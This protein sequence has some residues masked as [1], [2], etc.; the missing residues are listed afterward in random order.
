MSE[1]FVKIAQ[2]Q[3]QGMI[4]LRVDLADDAACGAVQTAL[5]LDVPAPHCVTMDAERGLVWMSKDEL[6]ILCPME[7]VG[8]LL[9]D[10]KAALA[11][12][13]HL[14]A[15]AS[16]ARAVFD[17]KGKM[18]RDVLAK[19]T[20]AD[21]HPDVFPMG[22]VRRTRLGQVAAAVWLPGK[23]AARVVCFRSVEAYMQL[24]NTAAQNGAQVM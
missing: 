12:V 21:M 6:L 19:L 3:N 1:T 5:G 7:G 20:P 4:T 8:A 22:Q 11:N 15:D 14:L 9:S 24:L 17:L 16:N 10:M 13:H 23:D 2:V 18:L